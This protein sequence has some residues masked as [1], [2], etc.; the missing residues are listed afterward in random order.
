MMLPL[1]TMTGF[2]YPGFQKIVGFNLFEN[3][4]IR[5]NQPDFGCTIVLGTMNVGLA[6][7]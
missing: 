4:F 1:M 7:R 5:N 3:L 2:P 6:A